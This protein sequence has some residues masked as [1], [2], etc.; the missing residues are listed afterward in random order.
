MADGSRKLA[1]GLRILD[2]QTKQLGEGLSHASAFLLAMKLNASD[3]GAA[4]FYISPEILTTT[5]KELAKVFMSADGHSA[6]Y[7]VESTVNPY[8]TKAMDQVKTI[9]ATARGAQANTALADALISMSG[10]TPY[11]GE[12]RD[13]Y[14][15]DLL[16]IVL[17]TVAVVFAILV[18]LLRAVVAPRIS[19]AP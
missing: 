13:Y 5:F 11:F 17:V 14:D 16:I 10:M 8:D 15:Q 12:L 9:L 19:L 6:R 1:D 2:D 3:P 18:L 7:L 4:G